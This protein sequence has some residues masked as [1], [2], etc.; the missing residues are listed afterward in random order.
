MTWIHILASFAGDGAL[1]NAPIE[2]IV[3]VSEWPRFSLAC[4]YILKKWE[5]S[6][7]LEYRLL[8]SQ[9]IH[10]GNSNIKIVIEFII[11]NM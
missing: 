1:T 10:I 4:Y 7:L 11:Q 2:K 9:Y 6:L 3:K 5:T 8:T